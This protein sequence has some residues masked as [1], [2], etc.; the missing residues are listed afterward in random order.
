MLHNV[1]TRGARLAR[2][3]GAAG[4]AKPRSSLERAYGAWVNDTYWLLMPYK[5]RDPGVN[6]AYDG[7]ETLDGQTYDKLLLTFQAGRA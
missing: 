6:L 3:P 7:E 4:G 5:L 1:D 2:R